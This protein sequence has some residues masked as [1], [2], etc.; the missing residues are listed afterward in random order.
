MSNPDQ[1][2]RELRD[3]LDEARSY[4]GGPQFSPSMDSECADAVHKAT[5]WLDS[6]PTVAAAMAATV[7]VGWEL[8]PV[9]PTRAILDA[10]KAT[11]EKHLL[12]GW[13][14]TEC[15]SDQE[16]ADKSNRDYWKAMI[17][18]ASQAP[19]AGQP[20][21]PSPASL[22]PVAGEMELIEKA[23]KRVGIESML[24]HGA[25]SCVYSEGCCGVTQAHLLAYTREIALPCAVALAAPK[26]DSNG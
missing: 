19:V 23:V 11:A 21:E 18:A 6:R 8:V 1:L 26:G 9:E 4:V 14:N 20:A 24:N 10:A 25:A 12:G 16:R 7:P 22:S 17:A 15:T 5:A 13:S 2:I 3:T